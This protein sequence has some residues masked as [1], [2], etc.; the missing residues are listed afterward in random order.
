MLLK[1]AKLYGQEGKWDIEIQQGKIQSITEAKDPKVQEAQE[2]I[3]LKP[4][5]TT[6]N[7]PL[8]SPDHK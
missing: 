5:E 1:N 4:A 3:D 2:A 6:I 7:I 8:F